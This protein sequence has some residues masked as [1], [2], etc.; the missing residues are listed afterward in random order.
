MEDSYSE[1]N[2]SNLRRYPVNRLSRRPPEPEYADRNEAGPEHRRIESRLGP[3]WLGITTFLSSL[4][5]LVVCE[6][7]DQ[8]MDAN[9]NSGSNGKSK[10]RQTGLAKIIAINC[11]E[12]HGEG[13]KEAEQDGEDDCRIGR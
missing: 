6:T 10:E 5:K 4:H 9:T 1:N 12:D 7:F 13:V 11:R 2:A 8:K 3:N